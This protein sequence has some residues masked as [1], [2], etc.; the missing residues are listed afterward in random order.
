MPLFSVDK[1]KVTPG[2]LSVFREKTTFFFKGKVHEGILEGKVDISG[3]APARNVDIS[4]HLSKIEINDIPFIANSEEIKLSG[5]LSGNVA[6]SRN[7]NAGGTGTAAL[8]VT[9]GE[10]TLSL[11]FFNPGSFSFRNLEADLEVAGRMLQLNRC[12]MNGN[13]A[14]GRLSGSITLE[15]PIGE[16]VLNL[17]GTIIPQPAFFKGPG[18]DLMELFNLKKGS[19]VRRFSLRITGTLDTPAVVLE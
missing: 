7:K 17:T 13:P 2:L 5:V 12:V 11:P 10:M 15:E 14:D 1:M 18:K 6:Y 19:D 16:S 4:T 3:T 8:S 9:G